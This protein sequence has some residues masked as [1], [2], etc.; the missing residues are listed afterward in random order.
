MLTL[1]LAHS[2]PPLAYRIIMLFGA[3]L[4]QL[5]RYCCFC[6]LFTRTLLLM[7]LRWRLAV[8]LYL[9][10]RHI[11][12]RRWGGA[13]LRNLPV[14]PLDNRPA[15]Q[16]GVEGGWNGLT[17]TLMKFPLMEIW[18]GESP[19]SGKE[20]P[21]AMTHTGDWLSGEQLCCKRPCGFCRHQAEH[22]PSLP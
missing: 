20:E 16:K 17:S 22:E 15:I 7:P 8:P 14:A 12:C 19:A 5:H 9:W 4:F 6:C 11:C 1:F 10:L 21:L 18:G 13:C 3:A 2:F